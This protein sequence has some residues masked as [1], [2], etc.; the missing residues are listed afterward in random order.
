MEKKSTSH[1]A[2]CLDTLFN[3]DRVA[4]SGKEFGTRVIC[5]IERRDSP[6]SETF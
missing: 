4:L 1:S 6:H 2:A 5:F 3:E